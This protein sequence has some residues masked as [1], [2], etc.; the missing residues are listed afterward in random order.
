MRYNKSTALVEKIKEILSLKLMFQHGN[1][2]TKRHGYVVT[3]F[4]AALCKETERF[5]G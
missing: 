3:Q 5:K 1:G 2:K 4:S